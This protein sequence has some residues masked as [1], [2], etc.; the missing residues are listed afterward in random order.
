MFVIVTN[1]LTG[2]DLRV[3]SLSETTASAPITRTQPAPLTNIQP[4]VP[5]AD[6]TAVSSFSLST[7]TRY[8]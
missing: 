6:S 2:A 7:T 4:S 1:P 8:E 3:D 5:G